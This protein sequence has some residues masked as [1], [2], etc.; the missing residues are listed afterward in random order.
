[1]NFLRN[2]IILWCLLIFFPWCTKN[3]GINIHPLPQVINEKEWTPVSVCRSSTHFI[4]KYTQPN[5]Q[6]CVIIWNGVRNEKNKIFISVKH[7]FTDTN[8]YYF[9]KVSTEKLLPL[10]RIQFHTPY[11]LAYFMLSWNNQIPFTNIPL[12]IWQEIT[13]KVKNK[14]NKEVVFSWQIISL[15]GIH[16][17]TNLSLFPGLSGSPLFDLSENLIGINTAIS[18][19]EKNM[20]TTL[21]LHQDMFRK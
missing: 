17:T 5:K 19:Q 13:A 16:I 1:M 9:A 6:D 18:T 8:A 14:Q 7:L 2:F 3:K 12:Q 20:S 11:D 21:M 4:D 15:S 10:D